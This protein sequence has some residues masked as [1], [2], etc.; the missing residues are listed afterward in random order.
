[1]IRFTSDP[2]G[3]INGLVFSQVD[4]SPSNWSKTT[5]P[6][7]KLAPEPVPASLLKQ[8]AGTYILDTKDTLSITLKGPNLL[9]HL[10]GR[11]SILLIAGT[12]RLFYSLNDDIQIEFLTPAGSLVLRRG[13]EKNTAARIG[14]RR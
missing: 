13:Q 6:P 9:L 7:L 8:Y 2:D 12:D 1:M 3:N 10:P 14:R 5:L 11:C 4:I